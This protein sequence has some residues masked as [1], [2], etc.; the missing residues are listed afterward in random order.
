MVLALEITKIIFTEQDIVCR[1]GLK[2]EKIL[3]VMSE[4]RL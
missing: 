3:A 4:I 2:L 1:F